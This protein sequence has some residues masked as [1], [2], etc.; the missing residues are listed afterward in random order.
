MNRLSYRIGLLGIGLLIVSS[1]YA[2]PVDSSR[3]IDPSVDY[4][5]LA[6]YAPWDDRNYQLT[7]NDLDILAPNESE[8]ISPVPVFFRVM[9][10]QENPDTSTTGAVQYPRALLNYYRMRFDGYLID[11]QIFRHVNYSP[12]Q[13]Y[14]VQLVAG[15]TPVELIEEAIRGLTGNVQVN[16]TGNAAESAV[17]YKPDD[18]QIVIA[19]FN[20][21][22][23]DMYFS[24]DGGETWT[25][26]PALTGNTCCDPA[27]DWSSDNSFAY[28]VTLGGNDVW[29]YRSDDNG[30]TWDSLEDLTPGDDR[31]EL[32]GPTGALDDKEYIH[33]DRFATSPF[34]DNIYITWHQS[35]IMQVAVSSDFGNTF[36]ITSFPGEPT[37]IG[38]DITTDANG[39][40]YHFWPATG[41][42]EIRMNVSADGGL[43]WSPSTVPFDTMA[44]FDWPLPSIES[45]RA[46]LY[47]SSDTDL[48]GGP[49]DGRMYI[50]WTDTTEPDSNTNPQLNHAVIRV[51]FSD[52][53]GATWTEST[54][55]PTDDTDDVDRWHQWLKVGPDGTVHVAFYDTRNF[56]DR[57]GVDFFTSFSEDGGAT[58][59]APERLTDVSS[60]N[61]PGG[62][63]FGDYNGLDISADGG[64]AIFTDSRD[65]TGGGGVSAD[66]YVAPVVIDTLD[67]EFFADGFENPA[68]PVQ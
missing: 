40:V 31:R 17:V 7:A 61:L 38:S 42:R 29:F 33:V 50:S 35:N 53:Q 23:Q 34:L 45:R 32:A 14:E 57:T 46:F 3:G 62:F 1:A 11:G 64:I 58:W 6:T 41:P 22:G 68:P 36:N 4:Q 63:E 25:E 5:S 47:V 55:H 28:V 8:L 66:V 54:P 49:F 18:S 20:G 15:Q 59:S 37:G 16:S 43:T 67:E 65:E 12:D 52:D 26:S 9:Y 27:M 19:G 39:N 24:T 13:G 56:V 44:S 51:A 48:T 21:S 10:R 60:P 2:Q 30:Q